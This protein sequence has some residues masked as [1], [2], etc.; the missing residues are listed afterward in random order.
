MGSTIPHKDAWT[1]A[2]DRYVEDLSRE[3]R[4][5]YEAASPE[6]IFYDASAAEKIHTSSS[7][8]VNMAD[9][10]GP[11]IAAIEQ[12]GKALDVY[13]NAYPL[14]LSPLWGSLRIVLHLAREFGKYF[15]RIVDMFARIGDLLPRFRVYENL[16]PSHER[17]VQALSIT[18]V[19]I[20]TF[21]TE[22][23][24]VF[25]R[26]RRVSLTNLRIL[27][28]L[29]WKPFERHF[30]QHIDNFRVHVKNVEKEA[31]L[32]HMIETSDSRAVVLANQGQLEKA[33]KEDAHWRIIA[34]IPS[35]DGVAK[36]KKLQRLRH[37]GTGTWILRH[38]VYLNWYDAACSSTLC[39]F[40]IPG[41]GKTIL[42]SSIVDTLRSNDTL[43]EASI[44]YYYCDYADQ[45]TLQAET[46]LG[47][48]LKQFFVNGHIPEELEKKFPRDYGKNAHTLDVNDLI[49]LIYMAIKRTSLTFVIIDGLDECEKTPRKAILSLLNRLQGIDSSIIKIFISCRQEDQMLRSLQ[50]IPMIQMTS[51]A[52][53]GDIR[54]FVAESVNSRITSGELRLR[55]PNLAKEITDEL[56]NKAHG[57]FLWVFFQLDDLCEAPS[58]AL[59]R[60][61]LR[62]LPNGLIETYERILKKIRRDTIKRD[63]VQ[64]I[65]M[66]L[67][68]ARR[69]LGIEE[70]REAAGF[71][72]DQ[73][74]WDSDLLP[75]ADLMTEA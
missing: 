74:S 55:D 32:S 14:V 61:T 18:Y 4:A 6:S 24:A 64:K 1:R 71:E 47:T 60:R 50:G 19:D 9:K 20:L 29:S 3:E 26:E 75:D 51:S 65:F 40:G 31:S 41:C 15:E 67:I 45:R 28:K 35:V 38:N 7:S 17:L 58:D 39:C 12:Y 53:E 8:G 59:I 2:R 27:F 43:Q 48:I 62:N 22:A 70:L 30:G 11:L 42:A 66:W 5:L 69:P 44:V 25:R 13:V 49:D 63:F 68:C 33:K 23:K 52:L 72:P 21:C 36:H 34:A 16:F 57:M 46:I 37:E 73:K 10:L 56:V 54:L